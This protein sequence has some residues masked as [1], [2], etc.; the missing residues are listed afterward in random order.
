LPS[1]LRRGQWRA[2]EGS[3]LAALLAAPE[4]GEAIKPGQAAKPGA[5][6]K[7]G[8]AARPRAG[9]RPRR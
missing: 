1:S 2:L 4:S 7:L 5:R 8:A 6:P 9:R 3:D